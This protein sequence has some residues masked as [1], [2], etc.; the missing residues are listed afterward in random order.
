MDP[1]ASRARSRPMSM[2]VLMTVLLDAAVHLGPSQY[3]EDYPMPETGPFNSRL[4]RRC[5]A[6]IDDPSGPIRRSGQL[7][8]PGFYRFVE[9]DRLVL[10][11]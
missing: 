9:Q 8:E 7:E 11:S 3:R 2:T 10:N 1:G 6:Q 5:G 4:R